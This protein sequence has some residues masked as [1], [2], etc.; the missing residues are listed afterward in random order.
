VPA[1]G[2][3]RNRGSDGAVAPTTVADP[4]AKAGA[5]AKCKAKAKAKALAGKADPTEDEPKAGGKQRG[6]L[7]INIGKANKVRTTYHTLMSSAA[8]MLKGSDSH[9]MIMFK[10][11]LARLSSAT[12]DV[13]DSL[14][15]FAKDYLYMDVKDIRKKWGDGVVEINAGLMAQ[16]LQCKLDSLEIEKN[17]MLSHIRVG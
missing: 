11:M 17:K 9:E 12:S 4:K 8:E 10:P 1:V 16:E 14:S 13:S 15:Q 7:Q 6:A 2:Q 5:K 3:K